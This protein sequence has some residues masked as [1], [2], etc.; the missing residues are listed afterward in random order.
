MFYSL[1]RYPATLSEY[2]QL[3]DGYFDRRHCS[4]L[5]FDNDDGEIMVALFIY[6]FKGET[7]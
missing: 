4:F 1:K 5:Y 3:H 2:Q 7:I 6:R